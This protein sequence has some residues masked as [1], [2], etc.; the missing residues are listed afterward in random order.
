LTRDLEQ[1]VV[2]RGLQRSTAA[3]ATAE[4]LFPL[5]NGLL[6]KEHRK[7]PNIR[8]GVSMLEAISHR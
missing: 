4:A 2:I 5:T 8:A 7:H 1:E 3:A 6:S